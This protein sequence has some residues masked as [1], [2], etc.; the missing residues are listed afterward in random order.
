MKNY[1][2]SI[3]VFVLTVLASTTVIFAQITTPPNGGNQKA[4]VTQ[5]MGLASVTI[6]YHSPDV[7]SPA[8]ESREGNIWGKLVP[9]GLVNLGFGLSSASNPSPWRAGANENTTITFSHDMKVQGK[10]VAK[11]TYGLHMIPGEKEWTLILSK[12]N[13]SWGSFFYEP[14]NDALRVNVNPAPAEYNEWLTYEFTDRQLGSCTAQL[15]WENLQIPFKIEV[16]DIMQIYVE[17]LRAEMK[18]STGFS[19]NNLA[20]AANFCAANNINLEEGLQWAE[21]AVNAPFV[22][23]KNFTTL[24][25]KANVLNAMGKTDE[26]MATMT[27]AIESPTATAFQIHS[28]GRQLIAKGEVNEALKVFEY[29]YEHFDKAWPTNVGMA[30]GLSAKGEY[31]K[32]L[33]Y[34]KAALAEAPDQINKDFLSKA[35]EMLGQGKDIN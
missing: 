20:A 25:A 35:V 15:K 24:Q 29:N 22:G 12:D 5:W 32:A 14:A 23:Q 17:Q 34:A 10:P 33:K 9:Y 31:K 21:S 16:P 8:G 26:A 3:S 28:Y 19:W 7:T 2:Q 1:L 4:S 18:G 30:R 13:N 27:E 11:G 6:T